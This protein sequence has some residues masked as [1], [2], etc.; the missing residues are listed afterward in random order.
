MHRKVRRWRIFAIQGGLDSCCVAVTPCGQR[1]DERGDIIADG[2]LMAPI[3][4]A[5]RSKGV[6]LHPLVCWV[7][8]FDSRRGHGCLSLLS[9]V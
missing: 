8:G 4:V 7:C 1:T 2:M 9:L 6:F 3:P 5:A